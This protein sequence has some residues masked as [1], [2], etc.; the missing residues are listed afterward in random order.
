[1][2]YVQQRQSSVSTQAVRKIMNKL[3][4]PFYYLIVV[5]IVSYFLYLPLSDPKL[6][7]T[8][9]LIA[10]WPH[11]LFGVVGLVAIMYLVFREG[12]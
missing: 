12:N 7:Q 10:F 6:T 9:L 2:G 5:S 4:K 8:Q 11:Y 3:R 1:M